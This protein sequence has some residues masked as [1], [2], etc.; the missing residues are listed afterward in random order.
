MS[1]VEKAIDVNV[2]V[3][4]AY[5]QWT[6]FEEFPRF[7]DGVEE[8]RQLNDTKLHWKADVGGKKKE[9]DAKITEQIPDHRIAWRSEAGDENGG[10]VTFHKLDDNKTRIM[11]QMAYEPANFVESVGDKLGF[12]SRRVQGDLDRFKK[13]IEA[14][15]QE[16]GAWRGTVSQK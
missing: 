1:T 12:M 6:Q 9:W 11:L 8:V 2:P 14:R 15:G 13:F 4:T 16:T 3:R 10:V 5:N 7:M